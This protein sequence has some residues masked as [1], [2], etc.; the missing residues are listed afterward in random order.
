M[1]HVDAAVWAWVRSFVEDPTELTKGLDAYQEERDRETAPLR[2]R[3][4]VVDSLLAENR[5]QLERLLD[6]YLSGDL[7][8]EMLVDRKT[9]LERT[10]EALASERGRLAMHVE[11]EALS[12]DHIQRIQGSVADVIEGLEAAE[13]HF[14]IRRRLIEELDVQAI[15][16]VEEG[17]KVVYAR[18]MLGERVLSVA[19]PTTK[20]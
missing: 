11:A 12:Q 13:E 20:S 19:N 9:R 14:G 2:E 8:K 3:L 1:D 10:A 17:Q 5:A 4:T 15:L 18:C 7:P 6:L 16:A